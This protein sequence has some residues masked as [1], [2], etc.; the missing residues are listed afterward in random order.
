MLFY[1]LDAET[2]EPDP[3]AVHQ[4]LPVIAGKNGPS[5]TTTTTT[6]MNALGPA[7]VEER[8]TTAN[9]DLPDK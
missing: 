7:A 1:N 2:L 9:N 6:T 3:A 8:T 5:T 4:A